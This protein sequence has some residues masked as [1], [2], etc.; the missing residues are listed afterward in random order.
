MIMLID[1][2]FEGICSF[3]ASALP[4]HPPTLPVW[5]TA[6]YFVDSFAVH[7]PLIL[8]KF[9]ACLFQYFLN[10]VQ[11]LIGRLGPRFYDYKKI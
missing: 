11:W 9:S 4:P 1:P 6:T 10:C 8:T 7:S 3:L 5:D 2:L